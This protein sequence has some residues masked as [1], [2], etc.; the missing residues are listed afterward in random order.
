MM[1]EQ[2]V[3]EAIVACPGLTT[4]GIATATGLNGSAVYLALRVLERCG[5]VERTDDWPAGWQPTGDGS[6]LARRE[7]SDLEDAL[8]AVGDLLTEAMA[9]PE[10]SLS[11]PS[12]RHKVEHAWVEIQRARG[13]QK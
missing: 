1:A 5:E 4:R 8:D 13:R 11:P 6:S 12:V 3:L 7:I 2:R 10:W 9:L